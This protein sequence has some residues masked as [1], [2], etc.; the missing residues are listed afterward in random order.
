MFHRSSKRIPVGIL[1]A[2]LLLAMPAPAAFAGIIIDPA[3][4]CRAERDRADENRR[5]GTKLVVKPSKKSWIKFDLGALDVDHLETAT[6]MVAAIDD[7]SGNGCHLSVVNDSYTTG[8]DWTSDDL[9]WN[10]APANDAL[11]DTALTTDATLVANFAV[12]GPAGTLFSIDILAA[13]QADTDGIVQFVL[14]NSTGGQISFATHDHPEAA[15]R[16][17]IDVTEGTGGQARNPYPANRDTDVPRDV[18]LDWMPGESVAPMDVHKVYFGE[19]FNDVNDGISAVTLSSDSYTLPQQLDFGT[20][21]YWR[22]DEITGAPDFA[23]IKGETWS[24]TTEP[25]AY[26][27]ANVTAL[28]SSS[29]AG[30]GPEN[31]VNGSGLSDDLHSTE[32]GTMWLSDLLGPQPTWIRFDLAKVYA[33]HEMWV[34]NSNTEFEAGVG[35]GAREVSI[36]YSI[37]GA[38]FKTLGSGHEFS[39]APAPPSPDYAHN[40]TVDFGGTLANQVRLTINSNWGG[41][42]PQYGVSEVRFLYIPVR[43][44]EP[45]PESGARDVDVNATLGWRAGREAVTHNVLFSADEQAVIDG[46]APAVSVTDASYSSAL[47]LGSTYYWRVDEVNDA[48]TPATWQGDVWD[49]TTQEYFVVEGFEDYNDW[50]PDEI[51]TAW[52][53]GFVD[54]ANGAQVGNLLP[55]Y[56]E[57]AIVHGGRQSMPLFYGNTGGAT[58]SEGTR[59]FATAQDWTKHGVTVLVLYFYGTVGNTGQMYVKINGAKI[60]YDSDAGNIALEEWQVWSVD[61]ISSGLSVQSVNSLGVGI[62]GNGAGGTLYFD[63]IGLYAVARAP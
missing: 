48:E 47:D 51:Y 27:I 40:T 25:V 6:L 42:L 49:F 60:P 16:P 10:N 24:F 63:D 44:R 4:S 9:T 20:T 8:I 30:Q 5:S 3:E 13:L 50:P 56:A 61:L 59:T 2:L 18:V 62:D 36:D 58:Y 28:A 11:S 43:A 53:D 41:F 38:E 31:T 14:H 46:T 54:P 23:V 45:Y 52:E 37:D 39:Q 33:L 21:Y 57:T 22:V 29:I 7:E 19:S 55:P 34:W 26:P 1:T 35:Y 32:T 12:D 15:W 17:F